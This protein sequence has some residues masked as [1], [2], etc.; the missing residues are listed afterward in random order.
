MY[1]PSQLFLSQM[2]SRP[3]RLRLVGADGTRAEVD[4]AE[5]T[6]AWCPSDFSLGS[7][8]SAGFTAG[9]TAASFPFRPGDAAALE[10]ALVL[11]D[12]SE[13]TVP[14]GWFT[15]TKVGR[16]TD[17]DRF[18]LAGEDAVSTVL[19]GEFFCADPEHPPETALEVLEEI[20]GCCGLTL[21]GAELVPEVGLTLEYGAGGGSGRTMRE[22]VGMAA[23]MGGANAFVNRFGALELSRFRG[24]AAEVGPD[25]YY[26]SALTVEESDF[27]FGA[28]EVRVPSAA[29]GD[30]SRETETVY[31][32]QLDGESKGLAVAAEQF[33]QDAFQ[34]V[35]TGW[36]GV[37][38]RPASVSGLGNLLLDPGDV[39][40]VTDRA[41]GRYYVPV[42]SLKHSFDGG[43]RTSFAAY[44]PREA[45]GAA[46]PQTVSQAIT[47]LKTELGRFRHLYADNLT[48]VNASLRH[49]ETEDLVGEH[50]VL[51][52]ARGTFQFGDALSWDGETLTVRGTME[53]AS[54][55]VGNW[56]IN[57]GSLSRTAGYREYDS[58]GNET[59]RGSMAVRLRPGTDS[60]S[61]GVLF[62][63]EAWN[64][65]DGSSFSEAGME[66]DPIKPEEYP[67]GF[68]ALLLRYLSGAGEA[69]LRVGRVGAGHDVLGVQVTGA[70]LRDGHEVL[71][72]GNYED[73]TAGKLG[74]GVYRASNPSN[75]AVAAGESVTLA[76][77]TNACFLVVM[78]SHAAAAYQSAA[79]VNTYSGTGHVTGLALDSHHSITQENDRMILTGTTYRWNYTVCKL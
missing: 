53:A 22:A 31:S 70:L 33:S 42:M 28:L 47:G 61:P 75:G 32:D 19:A 11:E 73:Y 46:T 56:T 49:I 10:A 58:E 15:L 13:E 39:V 35:W 62:A 23:L 2:D 44:G 60:V 77:A 21:T 45:V 25:R 12:G 16:E 68:F 37:R 27:V 34:W 51:N 4:E 24:T 36:R 29:E 5:Y 55:S 38:F 78:W 63:S 1:E 30:G 54:G 76:V 66:V 65:L 14:L 71:D 3:F 20:C 26:E 9:V 41:G 64:T 8:C 57:G 17:S 72:A 69:A 6:S 59:G 48:A 40:A 50:G 7:V 18:S 43:F 79:L 74:Q 52:L 67:R